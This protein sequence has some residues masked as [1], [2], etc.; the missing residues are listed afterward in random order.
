[1]LELRAESCFEL[2]PGRCLDDVLRLLPV[3]EDIASGEEVG[4]LDSPSGIDLVLGVKAVVR[5]FES[6]CL[7]EKDV[8]RVKA[9]ADLACDDLGRV[10]DQLSGLLFGYLL[11]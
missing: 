4:A 6:R 1:M 11:Q 10:A 3:Q 8:T 9:D 7:V 2:G 5:H